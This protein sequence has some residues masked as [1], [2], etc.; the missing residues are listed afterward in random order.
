MSSLDK[1]SSY[2][3]FSRIIRRT[4]VMSDS[5]ILASYGIDVTDLEVFE[6]LDESDREVSLRV[7]LRRGNISCPYCGLISDIRIKDYKHKKYRF[8]N[9]NAKSFIIHYEQR[10]YICSCGKSFLEKN[11]FIWNHNYK[12]DPKTI[13]VVINYLKKAISVKDIAELV[14]LSPSSIFN[15]MDRYIKLPQKH[16]PE[17]LSIDEFLAFNRDT[18]IGKYPCLLVDVKTHELIDVI[19]SRR[20][21]WLEAYFSKKN[22]SELSRVKYIVIDMHQPYKEVFKKYIPHAVIAIDRFHYVRYVTE[23]IDSVRKRVMSRYDEFEAEYKL[24]KHNRNFLLAKDDPSRRKKRLIKYLDKYMNR[25]E[26]LEEVLSID[27]ELRK[28][29]SIGHNFLK[30]LD[31]IRSDYA[32]NFIKTTI[33]IFSCSDIKEF[34]DVAATF[35]NW[36]Q[37]IVN[38]FILTP[39][40]YRLTNGPI[41]GMNNKVKTIKKMAYG[42]VNFNHLK[43]RIMLSF[44]K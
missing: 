7:R 6:L 34:V 30:V 40:S 23:A 28:A 44:E 15:I 35:D 33:S 31:G 36:K 26:L 9:P 8:V 37:E 25:A 42:I 38:S 1:K 13:G 29:Y 19:R 17:I 2:N 11:P 39:D 32:S 10:R 27:S 20:K 24:L 22:V 14:G 3:G 43:A 16:L 41:E 4:F 5:L 18:Y 21:A 12:I